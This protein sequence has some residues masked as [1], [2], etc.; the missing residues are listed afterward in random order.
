MV[1]ITKAAAPLLTTVATDRFLGTYLAEK[2]K[3]AQVAEIRLTA[4]KRTYDVLQSAETQ[5]ER[6][7][8]IEAARA[9]KNGEVEARRLR[10]LPDSKRL[11]NDGISS[12]CRTAMTSTATRLWDRDGLAIRPPATSRWPRRSRECL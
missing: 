6:Q 3:D 9:R 7:K 12:W 5:A 2:R 4:I 1:A 10:A 11:R 8:D